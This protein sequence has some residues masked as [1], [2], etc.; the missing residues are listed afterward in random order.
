MAAGSAGL[1]KRTC[2]YLGQAVP[3]QTSSE[4]EA[5][6]R[7]GM[8]EKRREPSVLQANRKRRQPWIRRSVRGLILSASVFN[9]TL[10][11]PPSSFSLVYF[12]CYPFISLTS[13]LTFS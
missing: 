2:G 1:R 6:I 4:E 13:S 3:T 7:A 8:E 12:L 5:E 11:S 9:L 10:E